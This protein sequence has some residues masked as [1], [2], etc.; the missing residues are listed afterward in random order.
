MDKRWDATVSQDGFTMLMCYPEKLTD[1]TPGTYPVKST[2][3]KMMKTD[4]FAKSII[5]RWLEFT[6][7]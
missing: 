5:L 3:R 7:G 6:S 2:I 1:V 4:N